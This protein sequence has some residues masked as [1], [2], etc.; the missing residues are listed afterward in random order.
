MAD[1]PEEWRVSPATDWRWTPIG[2]EAAAGC[3]AWS[4]QPGQHAVRFHAGE[5][6]AH[7]DAIAVSADHSLAASS[8]SADYVLALSAAPSG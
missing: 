3:R 1:A 6:G 7:L 8:L 5:S 4:L 2:P